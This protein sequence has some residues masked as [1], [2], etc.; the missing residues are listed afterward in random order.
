[1]PRHF[2]I[3]EGEAGGCILKEGEHDG[4]LL[5][6]HDLV[7]AIVYVRRH[8]SEEGAVLR[9]YDAKGKLVHTSEI[10]AASTP[11]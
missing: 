8:R 7:D 10:L 11:H 6:F 1:V 9:R 2:Y 4:T 5:E 3:Y